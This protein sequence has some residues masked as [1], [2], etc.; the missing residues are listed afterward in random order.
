LWGNFEIVAEEVIG[1]GGIVTIDWP[2]V[3]DYWQ[4]LNVIQFLGEFKF[5]NRIFHGCACGLVARYGLLPGELLGK[6][7]RG[8]SSNSKMLTYLDEKCTIEGGDRDHKHGDHRGVAKKRN[9]T[10]LR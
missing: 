9:I 3:N 2:E 1:V 8:S 7:W 6:S 4:Q 5:G 10:P